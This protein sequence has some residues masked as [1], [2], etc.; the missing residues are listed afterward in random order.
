MATSRTP[1]ERASRAPGVRAKKG[2]ESARL[3]ASRP[4]KV[5]A[6]SGPRQALETNQRVASP[7]TRAGSSVDA[8][9]ATQKRPRAQPVTFV[10][11]QLDPATRHIPVQIISLDEERQHGLSHGAFSYMVKPATTEDLDTAFDRLAE[12]FWPGPPRRIRK[13]SRKPSPAFWA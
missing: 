9:I 12:K 4:S 1:S 7:R 6:R 5:I 8:A 13:L 10:Q 11:V 3:G 2:N